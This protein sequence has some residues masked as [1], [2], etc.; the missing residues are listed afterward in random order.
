MVTSFFSHFQSEHGRSHF[1]KL[2]APENFR[3]TAFIR[4]PF[5]LFFS[6]YELFFS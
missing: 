6:L 3:I 5:E 2:Q 4:N 1:N